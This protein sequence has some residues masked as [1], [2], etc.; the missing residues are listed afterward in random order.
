MTATISIR[1]IPELERKLGRLAAVKTLRPPMEK[2]VR[3]VHAE[4]MIY[5]P[6][7]PGN[8]YTR[9]DILKGGWT[10]RVKARPK[11]LLGI[12]GNLVKYGPWVQSPTKQTAVHKGHGWPTTVD[13]VN[14]TKSQIVGA[15]EDAIRKV[16]ND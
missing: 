8:T 12:V 7:F 4:A 2:A 16:I 6:N 9:Q 11:S 15:F 10:S 5:P 1:G 14:E 3:I 13:I